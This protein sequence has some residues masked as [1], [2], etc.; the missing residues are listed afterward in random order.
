MPAYLVRRL[1]FLLP[2]A[3]LVSFVTFLLIH[4]VPGNPAQV[5]L[6]EEAT[7]QNVAA[8][9]KQL[10]LDQPLV[11]QYGIWLWNM[12][13]G[14]LGTSIQLQQPVTQ[15]ILERLP[16]TA[17]LGIASLLY[18]VLLA[19]PLGVLAAT[20]QNQRL[21]WLVN[22]ISL[23]GTAIPSFVLSLAL[24]LIFAVLVRFFPPGGYVPFTED[25]GQNLHD[26]VLPML[27]LGTGTV[28][29]NMRQ[30]RASMIE[31]LSQ[32]YIK[33]AW[34]K[35]L[36]ANRVYYLHALR[37]ALLPML[38]LVG[39]QAGAILGGAFVI[40]TIFLWPGVGELAIQSILAK[41]YPVVQGIVLLAAFSYMTINLLVDVSYGFLDPR[42]TYGKGR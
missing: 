42:I 15:A 14:D 9:T 6:G 23:F 20:H 29:V 3:L 30:I 33:T 21:D 36:S 25:P 28:A 41:D 17:E 5:L 10:G 26:L 39:L 19:V 31:V 13:H 38:T 32:D 2:V 12:L 11:T 18:S 16:V 8:L 7:P 22:I 34:A 1:L 37:N 27:A 40:E 4:L 24:V 35:G